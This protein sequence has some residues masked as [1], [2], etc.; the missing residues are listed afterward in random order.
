[1]SEG[2]ETSFSTCFCEGLPFAVALL[3]MAFREGDFV[4]AAFEG[5][6]LE[7]V[8]L[9]VARLVATARDSGVG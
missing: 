7:G 4:A 8:A 6:A 3:E 9:G 5:G 2:M 1:M